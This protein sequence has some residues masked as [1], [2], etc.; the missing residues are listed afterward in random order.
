MFLFLP[1]CSGVR[2]EPAEGSQLDRSLWTESGVCG[3]DG[4]PVQEHVVVVSSSLRESVTTP[5]MLAYRT[6][7]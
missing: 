7:E 2:E 1:A 6:P 5:S 3:M 4:L